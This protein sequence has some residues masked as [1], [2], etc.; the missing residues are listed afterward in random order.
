MLIGL[1]CCFQLLN[2]SQPVN[3]ISRSSVIMAEVLRA[4]C[5]HMAYTMHMQPFIVCR[6]KLLFHLSS[7][8]LV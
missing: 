5:M 3:I 6:Y 8:Y 2:G 4:I 7:L 1:Q